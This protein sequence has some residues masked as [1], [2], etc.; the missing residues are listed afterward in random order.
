MNRKF[1]VINQKLDKE[2]NQVFLEK[3]LRLHRGSLEKKKRCGLEMG[4]LQ[5]ASIFAGK[6]KTSDGPSVIPSNQ[7]GVPF[8]RKVQKARRRTDILGS[9]LTNKEEPAGK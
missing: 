7:A 8:S 1:S 9:V 5:S 4:S 6:G 2:R 3:I